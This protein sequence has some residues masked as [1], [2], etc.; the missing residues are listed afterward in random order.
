MPG[1]KDHTP[2][3]VALLYVT[4][5]PAHAVSGPVT[6]LMIGLGAF[7][8]IEIPLEPALFATMISLLE[9]P[10]TSVIVIPK[11]PEKPDKS[12]VV[13]D[14]LLPDEV[15]LA[16]TIFAPYDPVIISG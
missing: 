1:F 7:L 8:N 10:S 16:M 6:L 14:K 9:S 11:L 5:S 13:N 12:E 3:E 4:R 2:P 15:F